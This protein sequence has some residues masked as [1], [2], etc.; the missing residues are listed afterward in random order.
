M[1]S[2]MIRSKASVTHDIIQAKMGAARHYSDQLLVSDGFGSSLNEDT[3][4]WDLCHRKNLLNMEI[5]IV[6]MLKC[7]HGSRQIA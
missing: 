2:H 6:G 7:N 3:Q 1:I 4:G 5:F